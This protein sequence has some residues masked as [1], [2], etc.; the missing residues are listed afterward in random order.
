MFNFILSK[1]SV[2]D[3]FLTTAINIILQIVRDWWSQKT[4]LFWADVQ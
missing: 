3:T 1:V 2:R 4:T